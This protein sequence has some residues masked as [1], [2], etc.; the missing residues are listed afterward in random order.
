VAFTLEVEERPGATSSTRDSAQ[1][2]SKAIEIISTR[3]NSAGV[4]EPIVRPLGNNR[5][6]VQ[7]PGFPPRTTPRSFPA[8]KNRL[9][10]IFAECFPGGLPE[11][12]PASE[13]P[14]GY[15]PMTLEQEARNGEM[16]ASELY[17]K[18]IPR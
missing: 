13:A 6:E 4:A 11:T 5:I 16:H 15:E 9:A 10:S 1:Q 12:I 2:L 8:S 3:I 7:L 17:V 18:R 14:A